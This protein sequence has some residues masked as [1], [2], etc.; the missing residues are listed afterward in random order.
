VERRIADLE[1][2]LHLAQEGEHQLEGE[3][4]GPIFPSGGYRAGS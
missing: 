4:Q 1:D 2:V 3:V